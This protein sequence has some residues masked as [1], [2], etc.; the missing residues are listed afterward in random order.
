[1]ENVNTSGW[2]GEHEAAY[3]EERKN[4]CDHC[5]PEQE[6][7]MKWLESRSAQDLVYSVYRQFGIHPKT[8]YREFEEESA[9]I[10]VAEEEIEVFMEELV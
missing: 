3:L 6:E 4:K 9:T 1:M 8:I 10:L 5:H 7:S 2:T